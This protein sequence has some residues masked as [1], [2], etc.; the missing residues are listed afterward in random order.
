QGLYRRWCK[1]TGFFS[2]IPEDTKARRQLEEAITSAKEQTQVDDHFHRIK[3]E[4]KPTP[5]SDE[6]FKEAAI[7]WLVETDQP[8]AAFE[9]PAFQRMI[10]ITSRAGATRSVQI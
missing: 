3:P 1:L 2:M 4:D 6:I 9:H 5:Y 10:H 7:R 8:V